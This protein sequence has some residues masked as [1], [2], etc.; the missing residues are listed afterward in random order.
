MAIIEYKL[1][2]QD[3][4]NSYHPKTVPDFVTDGGYWWDPSDH[5]MI[6]IVPDNEVD[7][8]PDTTRTR[9]LAEVQARQR[10]IYAVRPWSKDNTTRSMTD[11]EVNAEV[12]AWFD[13][14]N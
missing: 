5:T 2:P 7:Q 8:L 4:P 14:R 11:N 9:T 1:D 3:K 6:T 12:K 10:T 13:E